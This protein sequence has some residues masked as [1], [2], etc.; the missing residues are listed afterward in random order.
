MRDKLFP[1]IKIAGK[2]YLPHPGQKL[3]HEAVD[4]HRFVIAV[5]G[6]RFGK[7]TAAV[8]E[9]VYQ[10][11]QPGDSFGPPLVYL[12][13]DTYDHSRK[14]FSQAAQILTRLMPDKGGKKRVDVQKRAGYIELLDTGA[15]IFVKSADNP[16][17][18]AG[19][20]VSFA[21]I[22]ES[23]FVSDY[24]MEV[25]F[26]SFLERKGKMLAIGTPDR[27]DTWFKR[28]FDLGLT[29]EDDDYYSIQLPSSTNPLIDEKELERLREKT[30]TDEYRKYYLAEFVNLEDNPLAALVSSAII[31]K[32][33]VPPLPGRKYVAGV[34]L[35]D[36][37]DYTAVVIVDVTEKPYKV[38]KVDRWKG[39]GYEATGKKVADLLKR[40]NNA[41]AWVDNTGIGYRAVGDI[42]AHY[43]NIVRV[44]FD[45]YNKMK[46]FDEVAA[47]LD[48]GDL[49]L[50]EGH[51]VDE[52]RILRAIQRTKGVSYEAPRGAHDD[53]AMALF[54]AS[55]GFNAS[56]HVPSNHA[57]SGFKV[58]I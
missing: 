11:I 21:V 23:S 48:N 56:Y 12:V 8:M 16:S 42:T 4:N 47:H 43:G 54:L 40:Y 32:E 49:E 25:L 34:D 10:A 35:A 41:R 46:M 44:T 22:E 28:A 30:S 7:T 17:S 55:N 29:G 19:D 2:P 57:I 3:L 6:R 14:M 51:L 24:A 31:H 5:C 27:S 13:S 15:K 53:L 38:V 18:L 39:I 52:L 20:G 37:V 33:P 58:T 1:L 36:R 26:P 9:T 50:L 45:I